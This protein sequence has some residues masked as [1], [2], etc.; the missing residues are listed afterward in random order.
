MYYMDPTLYPYRLEALLL[1]P[2]TGDML[3]LDD[4]EKNAVL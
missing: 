4:L 1:H 2:N 3:T